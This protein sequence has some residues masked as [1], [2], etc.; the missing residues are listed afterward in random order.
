MEQNHHLARA[1]SD[2]AW[3]EFVR[4]LTYKSEWN[5]KNIVFIGRFEPSS[6]LCHNCGYIN[7]E[8]QLKDR[9]WVCPKCGTKLDRDMNAAI[10]IKKITLEKQNLIG[11]E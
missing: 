9:E 5:G 4:E 8:L 7:T 2:A 6:K 10:N 1:I 11:V 3:G